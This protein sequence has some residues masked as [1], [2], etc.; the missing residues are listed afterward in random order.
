MLE[1]HANFLEINLLYQIRALPNPSFRSSSGLPPHAL[2]LHLSPTSTANILVTSLV[3]APPTSSPF[4][5]ISADAEVI[6]APKL[7]PKAQSDSPVNS[8]GSRSLDER[9]AASTSRTKGRRADASARPATF[10]RGVGRSL[11]SDYFD[12]LEELD[13]DIGLKVWVDWSI[14]T[15]KELRGVTWVLV[16]I[17]RPLGLQGSTDPQ[18]EQQNDSV[19]PA[20]RIAA[21]ICPWED[22]PDS[23]HVAL[24]SGLCSVLDVASIVGETVRL[25]AA[26]PQIP[27]ASVRALKVVPFNSDP[28]KS[29]DG[30]QFG[31]KSKSDREEAARRLLTMHGGLDQSRIL[32]GPLTDGMILP[33]VRDDETGTIWPGGLLKFDPLP[34]VAKT[35]RSWFL[36]SD[37]KI[38]I[39]T[40]QDADGT[41]GAK[42]PLEVVAET[43]KAPNTSELWTV[44]QSVAAQFP[45]L[46]CVDQ[47]IGELTAHVRHGSSLLLTGGKG[48]GKTSLTQ[49]LAHQLR[50]SAFYH[51]TYVAC[52]TLNTDEARIS[53]IKE[54][55]HRA[56][57]LA[58]WGSRNGGHS[59]LVLDDLDSLC[60]AETELQVG[61]ENGR[62][63]QVSE[64]IVSM[65]KQFC[66][67]QSRVVLVTTG[68][69]KEEMS[70]AI[71]GGH[72]VKEIINMS[73]PDKQTRR[74][75][76]RG[77]VFSFMPSSSYAS[78]I[79]THLS[80]EEDLSN[81]LES[82]DHASSSHLGHDHHSHSTSDP[83]LE[84]FAVDPSIDFLDIAG[85]TDGF[86]PGDLMLL[87][88]RARS[89]ALIRCASGADASSTDA[90]L[91]AEDFA[92]ARKGFTPSSLRNV[93]LQHSTVTFSSIGGLTDT[94]RTLLETLQYPT[95]YAPIFA[96]CPLRLRSGLL[97]YGYPG[98]G[99][100]LLASAV[101]GECGLNF[102]S[103][104]G[105]EI[106]NKYI[107]ASEKAVRD[108]FERA[109]AA[110]PCV[111]FFDEF[112]SVAPKRGHDSTGVT[113]RVVNQLLTQMDG[114]EG[115]SGVY[116]LAATSRP[117][118]I[119]PALLRPGRLDKSLLCD[120]P[121]YEDRLEILRALSQKLRMSPTL[122]GSTRPSGTSR[123]LEEVARRTDGFSGADL[124]AVAYNAH[125]E[126]IHDVLGDRHGRPKDPKSGSASDRAGQSMGPSFPDFTYFRYGETQSQK[127]SSTSAAAKAT[128]RSAIA[129]QL[130]S[131]RTA[132][133]KAR[134]ARRA[135]LSSPTSVQRTNGEHD[136]SRNEPTIEWVHIERSLEQTRPSI[137]REERSRLARIYREFVVGRNGEMP[138]GQGGSE[139]GGR[140][141]LM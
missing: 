15:A 111:L 49:L 72:V 85:Q 134:A 62:S 5:K 84:N 55:L 86:M 50:K 10:L 34:G 25:E 98:C 88:S 87:V 40:S 122:L 81:S 68:K 48:S 75:I 44:G 4:A 115:L 47:L 21:Q 13:K 63:R 42:L 24:S 116:V 110:R 95:L 109:Q 11:A 91:T 94:R 36:G 61:N 125:L 16:S 119:D 54:S 100:T 89:E 3:P 92:G 104:K 37:R 139:I 97:L 39:K 130:T 65:T 136:T 96:R 105:P 107:G 129:S 73:A 69:S 103:V 1:L 99:K 32:D 123:N 140:S 102:I 31:N 38:V 114:A 56:F 67:A 128:E 26:P 7:R 135:S 2:T 141:S 64:L 30:L 120:M 79:T 108:L 106:L 80:D 90:V 66:T 124:Q 28:A 71:I 60:P 118:L 27:R 59:L 46:M 138:S 132:Q 18:K 70:S 126:A 29:K 9:S 51:T 76:L 112:D 78:A 8:K 20:T 6:V 41:T 35:K 57:A 19:K 117:D 133:Q 83:K 23:R 101:A 137:S 127:P 113:D 58:A 43:V 77:I 93:T 121:G 131:H 14:L 12:D 74:D 82:V 45:T 52:N 22:A 53:S 33:T 17:V